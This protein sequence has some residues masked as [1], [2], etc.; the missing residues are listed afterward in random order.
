MPN[1]PAKLLK[2]VDADG[3]DHCPHTHLANKDTKSVQA[4]PWANP[5]ERRPLPN[6][7]HPAAMYSYLNSIKP[8]D[9]LLLGIRQVS[10]R[11]SLI[12]GGKQREI[13]ENLSETP[14]R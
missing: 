5:L 13:S 2:Q 6:V 9:R 11:A 8:D 10:V 1:M 7:E 3:L 12:A 14:P 4:Q